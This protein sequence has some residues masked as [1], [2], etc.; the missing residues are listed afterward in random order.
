MM[1]D[2]SYGTDIRVSA[3]G[4]CGLRTVFPPGALDGGSDQR[5][6]L[7]RSIAVD[8][9]VVDESDEPIAGVVVFPDP[10]EAYVKHIETRLPPVLLKQLDREA[11]L[12]TQELAPYT[13]TDEDGR[14][15]L[16]GLLSFVTSLHVSHPDF[17]PV[18]DI[19]LSP[20]APFV[21]VR[22]TRGAGVEGTLLV[23]GRPYPGWIDWHPGPSRQADASG[24]YQLT[25]LEPGHGT[26]TASLLPPDG[27]WTSDPGRQTIE[28]ELEP[29]DIIHKDFDLDAE[30]KTISGK[31]LS[32]RGAPLAGEDVLIM[33]M[34][35]SIRLHAQSASDGS[36]EAQ[37]P[38]A[39]D[40]YSVVCYQGNVSAHC[41]GVR[42]GTKDVD[43]VFTE[44]ARLRVRAIDDRS[45]QPISECEFFYRPVGEQG[46]QQLPGPHQPDMAPDPAGFLLEDLPEGAIEVLAWAES[47]GYRR[48][49][50]RRVDLVPGKNPD[51]ELRLVRGVSARFRFEGAPLPEDHLVYL[52]ES[53][54]LANVH[55]ER[56]PN[57]GLLIDASDFPPSHLFDRCVHGSAITLRGLAPGH[58]RFKVFP[59]DLRI[60]P[61]EIVLD[62]REESEWTLTWTR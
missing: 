58:Y 38:E 36:W 40:G 32:S 49:L 31:V 61:D 55:L 19:P 47:M 57:T 53:D 62:D 15:H 34:G 3:P 1:P 33:N 60:T 22:L 18:K 59:D 43:L 7:V 21:T 24:H 2:P 42:A 52:I 8:G 51:L 20:E 28:L 12:T 39:P 45:G 35:G 27:Q 26:L 44:L 14:F 54:K 29:G 23:K 46:F 17:R 6:A 11:R 50:P 16:A 9:L 25:G 30:L 56:R 13:R 4:Y 41:R 37:V 10:T 48:A 5:F